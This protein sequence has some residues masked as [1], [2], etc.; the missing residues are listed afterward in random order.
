MKQT[1]LGSANWG[2]GEEINKA[3]HG[4]GERGKLNTPLQA[5][6]LLR[7]SL[8]VVSEEGIRLCMWGE[9]NTHISGRNSPASMDAQCR[10]PAFTGRCRIEQT[11]FIHSAAVTGTHTPMLDSLG[12]LVTCVSMKAQ[13]DF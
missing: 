7:A 1:V 6:Q 8:K 9:A 11:T 12:V 4:L 10:G 3:Y 2:W 5:G 13:G